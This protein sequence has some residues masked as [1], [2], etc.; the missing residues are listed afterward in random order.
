M[1]IKIEWIIALF[2]MALLIVFIAIKAFGA[3]SLT[4]TWTAPYA[5]N[6]DPN[7]GPVASYDLR[8]SANPITDANFAAATALTT[9]TPKAPGQTESYV[10]SMPDLNK[11][12]L[13]IKSTNA[14]GVVSPISNIAVKDFF[15]PAPVANLQVGTH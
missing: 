7:S 13:A 14:E 4:V 3:T 9:S 8:Y 11:Y 2:A 10:F 6:D 15:P 5:H 1:K 12:Y